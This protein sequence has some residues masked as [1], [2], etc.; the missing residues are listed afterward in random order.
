M[1][2][3][4]QGARVRSMSC[5]LLLLTRR[6]R[7]LL[8]LHGTRPDAN[9]LRTINQCLSDSGCRCK[10]TEGFLVMPAHAQFMV[11]KVLK[12]QH[13]VDCVAGSCKAHEHGGCCRCFVADCILPADNIDASTVHV[14]L[15]FP[16]HKAAPRTEESHAV[17]TLIFS[18]QT[19]GSFVWKM[20]CQH[21]DRHEV[22]A[23]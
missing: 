12:A 15:A 17:G 16:I 1:Q 18:M 6:S 10:A 4:F 9:N 13:Q 3:V 14:V 5:K 2:I 21:H 20:F 22:K 19:T 7:L 11:L 23:V 8:C